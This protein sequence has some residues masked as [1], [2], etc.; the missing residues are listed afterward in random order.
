MTEPEPTLFTMPGARP[1]RQRRK[2]TK[3]REIRLVRPWVLLGGHAEPRAHLLVPGDVKNSKGALL[4][5]CGRAGYRIQVEGQPMA[6]LCS[7]CW[8]LV[9]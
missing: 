8:E 2:S 7:A 1:T 5:R 9:Q 3:P 6:L 4:T